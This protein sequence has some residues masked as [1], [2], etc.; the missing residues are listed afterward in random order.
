MVNNQQAI[1]IYPQVLGE[2]ANQIQMTQ[3]LILACLCQCWT[4]LTFTV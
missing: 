4:G 3:V 1:S 2:Q